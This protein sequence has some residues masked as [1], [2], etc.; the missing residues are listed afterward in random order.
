[1]MS[2]TEER[3]YQQCTNCIMDTT[4]PLIEF[5]DQGACNHCRNYQDY[6]KNWRKTGEEA[7]IALDQMVEQIKE[8]GKGNK[9]DCIL[10]LSGGV[11]SSYLCYYA[12]KVLDLR[13]LVVHVDS[14]W[15]SELAVNNIENIVTKLNIDLHTLVL[16]WEEMKDLQRSFFLASVPNCDTPQDHAFIAALYSEAR[17]FNIHHILNGGNMATES[18]LPTYWGYDA[19]DSVHLK[20]VH[21]KYGKLKLK[22]YPFFT[23]FQQVI[24]YPRIYKMNVHRPLELI[25][26]NKEEVKQFL[27]VKLGWRDYGGKHYESRFTKF[28]QAH[29]LPEKFG[30][31]KRIAHLSSLV[32]SGQMSREQALKEASAPLYDSVELEED[33][34]YIRKKLG[35]SEEEWQVIMN[36]APKTEEHYATYKQL[37]NRYSR[38]LERYDYY[39]GLFIRSIL[40]LKRIMLGANKT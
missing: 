32:V 25:D 18:I 20:D 23:T 9:Y 36:S 17:K 29:Y 26:Y 27:K 24:L 39:Y 2:K 22:H 37:R 19:A 28:F 38:I 14:G 10:G 8:D 6:E 1:M 31:D 40:F 12:K 30:F 33:I 21:K 34:E 35:F 13:I 5:D 4:D 7:K 11:D 3:S 16:D 15:N